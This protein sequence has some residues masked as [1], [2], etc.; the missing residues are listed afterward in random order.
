MSVNAQLAFAATHDPGNS[1]SQIAWLVIA[2]C[3]LL[4]SLRHL[5]SFVHIRRCQSRIASCLG[6]VQQ[7]YLYLE[8]I[9]SWLYGPSTLAE[10]LWTGG[11]AVALL[12]LSRYKAERKRSPELLSTSAMDHALRAVY[13]L[14]RLCEYARRDGVLAGPADHRSRGEEQRAVA[15]DGDLVPE[16]QLSPPRE[17]SALPRILVAA[18]DSLD[19]DRVRSLISGE[20]ERLMRGAIGGGSV[21]SRMGTSFGIVRKVAYEAFLVAHILFSLVFM[22]GACLH[23]KQLCYWVWPGF[24]L[25]GLDRGVRFA[26]LVCINRLW[27]TARADGTVELVDKDVVRL[28]VKGKNMHWKAGQ[29]A[30]ISIPSI[31][32]YIHESH[33]FSFANVP[34]T[35]NGASEAV[36]LVRIHDGM[37]LSSVVVTLRRLVDAKFPTGFTKRLKQSLDGRTLTTLPV[38]LEGPYGTSELLDHFATVVLVAGG[39]G[40]TFVLSHFLALAL[41]PPAGLRHLHLVWNIR[42][43]RHIRWIAP[44]LDEYLGTTPPEL[45]ITI[46]IHVTKSHVADEPG[47]EDEPSQSSTPLLQPEPGDAAPKKPAA[48]GESLLLSRDVSWHFGRADLP[49]IL[50]A[51]V[52]RSR[53][54]MKVIVCGPVQLLHDTRRA[55]AVINSAR[56]IWHGQAAIEY[57]E[58]SFG[59]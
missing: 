41:Q 55:V 7:R 3:V 13:R 46:D 42:H 9:P 56:N 45:E 53:G 51:D 1:A 58:E 43:S 34:V 2:L 16:T 22:I 8:T 37:P 10:A 5:L 44:L 20:K 15:G 18:C 21:I 33:P 17:Q 57:F 50:Q 38:L 26:K 36:F 29:H 23:W 49:S 54:R 19:Q 52:G 35:E 6:A 28:T 48:I 14:V 30:C 24:V 59:W 12:G 25:W 32:Q 31:Q 39:T 4:L 27:R 47:F 11:Y 40:V